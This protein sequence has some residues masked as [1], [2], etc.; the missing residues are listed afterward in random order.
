MVNSESFRRLLT[1]GDKME[2]NKDS[3]KLFFEEIE[4]DTLLENSSGCHTNGRSVCC[5]TYC[6]TR[7]DDDRK[8]GKVV[9]E[10]QNDPWDKFLEE[11]GGVIQY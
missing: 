3:S 8:K 2:G 4:V 5:T 1:N 9:N 6:T 7:C 10:S 11:N